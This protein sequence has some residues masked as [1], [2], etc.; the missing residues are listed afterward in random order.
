MDVHRSTI[1][2]ISAS[3][4]EEKRGTI[5]ATVSLADGSSIKGVDL[6]IYATGY[7]PFVPI[8]FE[9][10]SLRLSLGLSGLI[11]TSS[12]ASNDQDRLG[13]SGTIEIPVDDTTR[14]HIQHW[15]TLDQDVEPGVRQTLAAT[16]CVP[17]DCTKPSW[18]GESEL[19]PYRLFRRMIAPRLAAAG[20]RSFATVGVVLTSTIA[21]VAEVQ[22]L[23]VTS[24]LTGGFDRPGGDSSMT[25]SGVLDL[26][27]L[28]QMVMDRTVSEDVVLGSLTGSGLEVDAI[29]V[30]SILPRQIMVGCELTGDAS[31][32]IFSCATWV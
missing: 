29:H 25:D 28:S 27:A 15:E 14:A 30:S 8:T 13:S 17:L 1:S 19:L 4:L 32:T 11:T 21:V 3:N 16:G 22:A 26:G 18:T 5:Q 20:D 12:Q 23:W 9:P 10:P 2:K 6:V 7:K 24:F 31:T